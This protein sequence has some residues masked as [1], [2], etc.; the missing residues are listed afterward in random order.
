MSIDLSVQ[1]MD[2]KI[3]EEKLH[4]GVRMETDP[5][6][7]GAKNTEDEDVTTDFNFGEGTQ[8]ESDQ[9]ARGARGL[10]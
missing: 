3:N 6:G 1:V 4:I 9:G 8:A 10:S 7:L 5:R 2:F